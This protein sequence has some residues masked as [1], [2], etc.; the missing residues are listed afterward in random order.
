M[1]LSRVEVCSPSCFGFAFVVVLG[2]RGTKGDIRREDSLRT[3][4]HEEGGVAGG[5]TS[6]CAQPPYYSRYFLDPLGAIFFDRV[7]NP[8]FEPLKDQAVC[9]LH[10]AVAPGV[11]HEGIVYVDAAFLAEVPGF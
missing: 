4:D 3:L 2:V 5:P 10:L 11:C 7:K 8:G 9:M 1:L 6:L